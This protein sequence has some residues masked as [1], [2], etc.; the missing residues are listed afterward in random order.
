MRSKEKRLYIEL[1]YSAINLFLNDGKV[2]ETAFDKW[3]S[4]ALKEHE[5]DENEKR[6]LVNL[7]NRIKANELSAPLR[8]KMQEVKEKYTL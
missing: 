8:Q 2:D 7:L 5:T 1:A 6:V 4:L 3:L